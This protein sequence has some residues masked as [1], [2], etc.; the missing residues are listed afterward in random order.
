[1]FHLAAKVSVSDPVLFPRDYNHVNVGGTVTLMETMRDTRVRRVVMASGGAIYGMQD[2]V[3]YQEDAIVHPVLYAVSK[4]A[5]EYYLHD[6]RRNQVEA[7]CLRIFNAYGLV[8][9]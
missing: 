9:R 6:C 1:M 2:E 4:L 8:S 5:A 3:P 7:V